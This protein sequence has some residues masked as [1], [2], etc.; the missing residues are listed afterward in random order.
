MASTHRLPAEVS[1]LFQRDAAGAL[2]PLRPQRPYSAEAKTAIEGS[3]LAIPVR[4]ALHLL[5]DDL[6]AA[7]TLVQTDEG[8]PLSNLVHAVL[9]RREGDFW[10]SK[11]WL[12]RISTQ[13]LA[14]LYTDGRRGAKKFV[15]DVERI[16]SKGTATACAAQRDV[17]D[18]K[19]WQW[20]ELVSI[21]QHACRE[22]NVELPEH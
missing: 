15:D 14:T 17:V 1:A 2:P 13:L 7:H 3:T 10:N 21:A 16:T 20:K 11:W 8:T 22:Y 9:H 18:A 19:D 5:N 6:D 12:D 4:G